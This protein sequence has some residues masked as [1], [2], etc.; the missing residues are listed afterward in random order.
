ME[1]ATS[2]AASPTAAPALVLSN[3]GKR[4][5]QAT[6]AAASP[7]AAPAL[8]LSNSGKRMEQATSAAASP[9]AAPALV[10]SNSGKRMEQATSAAASPTAAPALVLSNSGKRMEQATSAAASPTAAPALVLSNSGKRMEQAT[11]A[12]ASPTAAPALVLSNSGKRME[13]ATSSNSGKRMEQATSAAASPTAAPALDRPVGEEEVREAG[14]GRHNDTELHLAAQR[15]DLAAVADS[16]EIDAQV[17]GT[18]GEAE[19]DAEVAEIRAAVVNEVN[20]VE[21]TPLFIAAE[22]GFLDIVVELLKYSNRESLSRK[23]RSGFDALHVAAREG[24]RAKIIKQAWSDY[25][26]R[27]VTPEKIQPTNSYTNNWSKY[28]RKGGYSAY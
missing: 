17:T 9:T 2:A 20:E 13:Q 22:K 15:G 7:T 18:P 4:M 27:V 5:E 8:V 28:L 26:G 10:L 6:S 3:S 24:N 16:R 23:N 11:S 12:A 19:F 21:E 14:D 25:L 1:Q